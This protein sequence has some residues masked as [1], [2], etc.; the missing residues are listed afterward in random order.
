MFEDILYSGGVNTSS[1]VMAVKIATEG[2][3]KVRVCRCAFV[4]LSLQQG[5][6]ITIATQC[7]CMTRCLQSV[8]RLAVHTHTL[9]LSLSLSRCRL[10]G[11]RSVTPQATKSECASLLTT[12]NSPTWRSASSINNT[13]CNAALH[14]D[15]SC[16]VAWVH[17]LC[18]PNC[19]T[20]TN[21][22]DRPSWSRLGPVNAFYPQTN[23]T[24]FLP[25]LET[26]ALHSTPPNFNLNLTF[27][28][29]LRLPQTPQPTT[30]TN[31]RWRRWWS[32]ATS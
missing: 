7:Q 17:L 8:S 2:Q 16:A 21:S 4:G 12:T 13:C 32:G 15:C 30:V 14:Y 11:W 22:N 18:S 1:I 20:A 29:A 6:C 31:P 27:C 28:P 5:T 9:S 23:R 26:S 19:V 10:L 24:P 3:E 25:R